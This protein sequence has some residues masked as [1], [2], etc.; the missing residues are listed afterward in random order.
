MNGALP[1]RRSGRQRV[2]NQKY[3]ND[4]FEGLEIFSSES[5]EE[6]A[7]L[8][9]LQDAED[10][11]DFPE[12][13]VVDEPEDDDS[14]V[15]DASDGSAI[16]T[17]AE[18]YEDAHSYA[19]TDG[20]EPLSPESAKRKARNHAT[21]RDPN[22]HNRGLPENPFRQDGQRSR[23]KLFA[24]EGEEDILHIIRS[25]DQWATDPTLPRRSALCQSF[26]E[27]E[28]NSQMEATVG[29]DWYY[30]DGGRKYFAKQQKFHSLTKDKAAD[31]MPKPNRDS[32]TFLMGSY[33]RQRPFTL[34]C[35]QSIGLQSAWS[36]AS[37]GQ[38]TDQES[39][40][41]TRDG[42][43]LNIGARIRCLEWAPNHNGKTQY[44]A[45]AIASFNDSISKEPF[46]ESPSYAPSS[47][48]SAI[49]IWAFAANEDPHTESALTPN[50]APQ[51]RLV[52]VS[53]WGDV[54][55]VKWCPVPRAPRNEDNKD[56]TSLNIGLLAV[57]WGDGYARVNSSPHDFCFIWQQLQI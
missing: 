53:D 6:S 7:I 24:G 45:I 35:S 17:P 5:E 56:S 52:I 2:P 18:E 39:R 38:E 33:G 9:Q 30:D 25:R 44:L 3:T 43:M 22:V 32:H 23:L 13:Q 42:W 10:D 46:K 26:S 19:S 37:P 1:S 36:A 21:Y 31:Y 28:A 51:L 29:W 40:Q 27:G 15:E 16:L 4:A 54:K 14:L 8:E 34:S 41:R 55:H 50:Q 11:E 48:P 20:D 57:V 49:Q 47:S 12:D